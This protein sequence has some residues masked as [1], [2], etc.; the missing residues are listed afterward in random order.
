MGPTNV[1]GWKLLKVRWVRQVDLDNPSPHAGSFSKWVPNRQSEICP[2]LQDVLV[3]FFFSLFLVFLVENS[4][5][6]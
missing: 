2:K 5:G 3:L 1:L 6:S 4:S